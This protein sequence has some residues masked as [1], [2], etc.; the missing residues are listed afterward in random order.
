MIFV[1]GH[2]TTCQPEGNQIND[3]KA[4]NGRYY[5]VSQVSGKC[6]GVR[7]AYFGYGV[8]NA[9]LGSDIYRALNPQEV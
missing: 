1:K 7:S 5:F 4:E 6:L 9:E 2:E 3:S 8:F